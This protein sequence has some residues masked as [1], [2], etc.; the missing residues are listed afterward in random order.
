LPSNAFGAIAAAR[1][2]GIDAGAT[3]GAFGAAQAQSNK[4]AA[5]ESARAI[6]PLAI[7]RWHP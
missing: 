6:R 2:A 5:S 7:M 3:E 4:P 1:G